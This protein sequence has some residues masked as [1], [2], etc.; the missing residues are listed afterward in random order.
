MSEQKTG[1]FQISVE[2]PEAWQR[3]IKVQVPRAEY[4]RQ[5]QERLSAAVRDHKRPGFRKGKTPRSMVEKEQGGRLRAEAFEALVPQAYRAAVI[6]HQLY[7]ITEPKLENLV[8]DEDKDLAFDL[9][10]EVRP[11]VTDVEFEGLAVQERQVEITS[12]E[13]DE[14]LERLR[15]N[16]AV[17][18]VVDRPA[19]AGDRLVLDL[20]PRGEDGELQEDRRMSGQHLELG[21]ETNLPAFN[22]ALEGAT[23]GQ[24]LE[25][26]VPY[27]DDYPS[28][29]LRGRTITFACHLVQVE[30]KVTPE[31]D[32]AFAAQL[33]EGQT[34]LEL[35]ARIRESLEAEA[36]K[37]VS[38]DL[39]DQVLDRL[40]ERN[41]VPVPPSMVEA[42][43]QSGV[44]DLHQ[45]AQQVG[46]EASDADVAEYR[47]AARPAIE[48]QIK[49]MFLFEAVR[50]QEGI[51]VTDEDIDARV[52]EVAAEHGFDVDKYR[53]YVQ[54]GEEKDRI[55]H[56]ILER[57]TYD[58]L[59]SRAEVTPAEDQG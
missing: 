48:R 50:R 56:D 27:P 46:R 43:L 5:Y 44:Q 4:D 15:D 55:R 34:L 39:D 42:W 8:F 52:A 20:V 2:S 45:R 18:E 47:E 28:E 49:G 25:V 19:A 23:A 14:F 22:E 17:F 54:K 11:E 9:K 30:T 33:Q 35:R 7:P 12:A 37:R 32:D 16:R 40:I 24:D 1:P 36:K 53:Q 3:V 57:R 51:E 6:E 41:E 58:F 21:A 10:V 59:L 29:D 26:S 13:V 31:V 38:Q